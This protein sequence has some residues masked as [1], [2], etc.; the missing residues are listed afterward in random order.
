[1]FAFFVA[2][3]LYFRVIWANV[4]QENQLAVADFM[5]CRTVYYSDPE[6]FQNNAV[7]RVWVC[8][9]IKERARTVTLFI[10]ECVCEFFHKGTFS[11][12][13]CAFQ[14]VK[15]FQIVHFRELIKIVHETVG[16]ICA[17]KHV[18][19][20]VHIYCHVLHFVIK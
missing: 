8:A 4:G 14:D 19:V 3:F 17:K 13:R 6:V 9:T 7:K 15:F 20:H 2:K 11:A 12:A 1:M 18:F 5:R 10:V 16:R